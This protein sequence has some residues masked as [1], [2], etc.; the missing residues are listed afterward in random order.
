MRH[1]MLVGLD[2]FQF[3]L[4]NFKKLFT[5]LLFSVTIVGYGTDPKF[6]DYW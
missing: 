1:I 6:G 3:F 4:T 5:K 2:N